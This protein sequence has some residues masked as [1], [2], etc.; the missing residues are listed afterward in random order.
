MSKKNS[1][2]KPF[3]PAGL[4][5]MFEMDISPEAP[6]VTSVDDNNS[7]EQEAKTSS[8]QENN[9]PRTHEINKASNHGIK[10]SRGKDFKKSRDIEDEDGNVR[11]P[12]NITMRND[13][14]KAL[15]HLALVEEGSLSKMWLHLDEA[16]RQY[17]ENKGL[18]TP[19]GRVKY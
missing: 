15:Q 4:Q 1:E 11:A 3:I 14:Y 19:T 16:V 17:L 10:K 9:Q 5:G 7:T 18:F 12:H 8:R 13:Y 6:D 2:I